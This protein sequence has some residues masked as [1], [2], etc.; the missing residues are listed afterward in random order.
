[1]EDADAIEDSTFTDQVPKDL[2]CEDGYL[3]VDSQ[4]PDE[5]C[6]VDIQVG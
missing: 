1:M 6:G 5:G 2:C 3:T 4:N